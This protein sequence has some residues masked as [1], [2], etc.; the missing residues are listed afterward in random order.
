M[1]PVDLGS[2]RAITASGPCLS[3]LAAQSFDIPDRY[4]L[5]YVIPDWQV[6]AIR[7]TIA[8]YCV[9]DPHSARS[10]D[11]QYIIESLY[12]D[13]PARD[14]FL[15]SKVRSPRRWKARIRRY[16]EGLCP[17]GMVFLEV[18][19]KSCDL[20]KKPRARVPAEG[21]AERLTCPL[22]AD[23]SPAE[24]LFRARLERHR[25]VPTLLVRYQR[26][27]WT[28]VVDSYARVTFDRRV[29]CQPWSHWDFDGNPSG[30]LPLD[31]RRMMRTV[32]HAVVLEL[33]CTTAVPRWLSNL[34]RSAGLSRTSF[35][36][37]CNAVERIW[38][39]DAL[40]SFLSYC[41]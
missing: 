30:W 1:R 7:R 35:S 6:D 32:P 36:K 22:H 25:L 37:Y 14:L 41:T 3:V 39:R 5:K 29:T 12:L 31:N 2:P 23:A 34:I 20:I 21:W 27:A 24:R 15:A 28:S 19:K 4:E 18:K 13:T 11:H 16:V 10:A 8:P 9:L 38:G 40:S 17:T 26:E 33:K